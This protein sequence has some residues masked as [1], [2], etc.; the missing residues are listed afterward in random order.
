MI[1]QKS[2]FQQIAD[3]QRCRLIIPRERQF[4]TGREGIKAADTE[5]P[6]VS[7]SVS[8]SSIVGSKAWKR[9]MLCSIITRCADVSE[10]SSIRRKDSSRNFSSPSC[11]RV[12]ISG[13]V[14]AASEDS[15]RTLEIE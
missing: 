14:I 4:Q 1:Q 12:M 7:W 5:I 10:R 9:F 6:S 3:M 2:N 13:L 11:R 8:G 15:R